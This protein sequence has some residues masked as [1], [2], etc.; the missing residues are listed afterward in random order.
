MPSKLPL[1]RDAREEWGVRIQRSKDLRKQQRAR[2]EPVTGSMA[3]EPTEHLVL[4][5]LWQ[6]VEVSPDIE[7]GKVEAIFV[8]SVGALPPQGKVQGDL[9]VAIDRLFFG[10]GGHGHL[11]SGIAVARERRWGLSAITQGGLAGWRW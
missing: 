7:S 10:G 11:L 8:A 9:T 3:R 2:W 1:S 6:Q 5:R 4:Q